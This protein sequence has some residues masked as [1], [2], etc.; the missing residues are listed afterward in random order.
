MEY[1][2]I[3]AAIS[4]AA[5]QTIRSAYQKKMIPFLGEHGATYIRFFYALPFTLLI[6]IF[7]FYF[8]ENNIPNVSL[9]AM[10][11]CLIG[12]FC[13][14][15]FTLLLMI[16]F[17]FRNFATGIAF[18]KTEVLFAAIIEIFFLNMF[19]LPSVNFGILLGVFAVI[20]LSVAKQA[21]SYKDIMRQITSSFFSFGTLLGLLTGIILA[22]ST[23]GYRLA[24]ISI[25]SP[26]L[27]ATILLSTIAIIFQTV[28]FGIWLF[29]TKKQQFASVIKYWKQS[30][31]A[32]ISG[33]GATAGWFFAFAL[34][35]VAEVRAVGQIEIIFSVLISIIIF[36]E[37]FLL[38]LLLQLQR[39]ELWDK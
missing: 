28:V 30:L 2:W 6:F 5:L 29:Y 36:R 22:G 34:A 7:W 35:S 24:I 27:D 14:V 33:S 32:G 26:V 20:F 38:L 11:F 31:P 19:F 21:N 13:Q 10:F 39:S 25:N 15:A 4:A 12:A 16:I 23:L 18:S 37:N 1:L 3:L 9:R 17:S 8:L